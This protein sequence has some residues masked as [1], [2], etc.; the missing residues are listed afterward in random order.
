MGFAHSRDRSMTIVDNYMYV[1]LFY[2]EIDLIGNKTTSCFHIV[3]PND[4]DR[5]WL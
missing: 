2:V 1:F 4:Y 5:D 3:A